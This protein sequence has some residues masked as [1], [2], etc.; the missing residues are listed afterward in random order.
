MNNSIAHTLKEALP[1]VREQKSLKPFTTFKVGG[2]AEFFIEPKTDDDLIKAITTAQQLHLP[3][4]FLSGGSNVLVADAGIRGLVIHPKNDQYVVADHTLTAGTGLSLG[5]LVAICGKNGLAG[6]EFLAGIPGTVGG[7]VYG[8]AGW[9][10][11][12]IGNF[13]SDVSVITTDRRQTHWNREECEFVYRHSR[14]KQEKVAIIN[15]T[16]GLTAGDPA[17]IRATINKNIME[18]NKHQPASDASSGCIF[19]NPAGASAGKL[20]DEAG[21][22]GKIIGGAQISTVHGNFVINTGTATAEDIVMLISY[23]KQ[24]IRDTFNIQ[25]QE[26]VNYLGF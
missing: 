15:A 25:L 19:K 16:F 12:A 17:T 8:N 9:P 18:K 4:T 24:Q 26:E 14:L 1:A 6:L 23:I 5:R 11:I 13:V 20:I 7:A 2:P 22:Q 21:L 10:S 3:Y